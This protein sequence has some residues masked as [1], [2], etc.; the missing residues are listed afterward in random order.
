M[1]GGSREMGSCLTPAG[2]HGSLELD[3]AA[4]QFVDLGARTRQHL[5][6]DFEFFAGDQVE[7]AQ[8][9]RQN[10]LE[11]GSQILL[12]L[13]QP[14]RYQ[15]HKSQGNLVDILPIHHGQRLALVEVNTR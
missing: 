6:L 2:S 5:R 3:D 4:L 7:A 8:S 12:R 9:L 15:R 11:V 13:C 14:W 10:I 1:G